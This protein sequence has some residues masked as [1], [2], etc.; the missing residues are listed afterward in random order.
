MTVACP[1]LVTDR[2]TLKVPPKDCWEGRPKNEAASWPAF[3]IFKELDEVIGE[4]TTRLLLNWSV[5]AAFPEK[6]T[7]PETFAR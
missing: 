2:T 4:E 5:P 1:V 6:T 3:W 7:L